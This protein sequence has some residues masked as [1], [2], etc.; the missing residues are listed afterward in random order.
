MQGRAVLKDWAQ[1]GKRFP[2]GVWG[3]VDLNETD[4]LV[5][6]ETSDAIPAEYIT[7]TVMD[8]N[9]NLISV[10]TPSNRNDFSYK[11][12]Q[13]AA[14]FVLSLSQSGSYRFVCNDAMADSISDNPQQDEIVFAK[15]PNSKA[16]AVNKS[17]LTFVIGGASTL[18]LAAFL[19]II[20]GL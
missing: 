20:H 6:Y 15:S 4:L 17:N 1:S 10:S 8:L 12:K 16:Q 13:G 5:Y 11:D 2:L 18:I 9:D 14:L 7:L 3:I 19:Y